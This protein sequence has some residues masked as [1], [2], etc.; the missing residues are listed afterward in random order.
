MSLKAQECGLGKISFQDFLP[1]K[2]LLNDFLYKFQGR[3]LCA[4]WD[5]FSLTVS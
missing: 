5:L 4:E 3:M 2:A 1:I